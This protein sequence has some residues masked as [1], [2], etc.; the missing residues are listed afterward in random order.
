MSTSLLPE[1]TRTRMLALMLPLMLATLM[2]APVTIAADKTAKQQ[3]LQTLL[4]KIDK[5]KLVIDTKEDSKS[6]YIKQLKTIEINIG[7]VNRKIRNTDTQIKAR[8]AELKKLRATRLGHQ[9]EL[10]REN[11]YL[12]EQVYAAFTLGRQEKVKLLFSQRSRDAATQP[13]LL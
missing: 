12:A 2:V 4:K 3:Q 6:K 8:K 5:L 11:E 10:S 7:Q 13:C 9:R 1:L